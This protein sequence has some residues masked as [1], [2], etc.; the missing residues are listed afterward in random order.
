MNTKFKEKI[1][2]EQGYYILA[3]VSLAKA[4]HVL[5][6]GDVFAMLDNYGSIRR[7]GFEQEGIF[8]DG[9]RFVSKKIL[10][11]GTKYPLLLNAAANEEDEH[12]II[13]FTNP[14]FETENGS[15]IKRGTLHFLR[16]IFLC[17][18]S[19]YER[20]CI[21]NHGIENIGFSLNIEI[22]A[23]YEDIFE[24]R[25]IKREKRG[26]YNDP[27]ITDK[28]VIHSYTGL[29]NITRVT[30]FSFDQPATSIKANKV[31]F[32][33]QLE[34]NHTKEIYFTIS[35]RYEH[36]AVSLPAWSVAHNKIR[37]KC[38]DLKAGR[39]TIETSNN[40]FNHWITRSTSD[41]FML[42]TETNYGLYPYAGIP[43]FNTIF[44]R[45]GLITAME[46]LWIYPDISKGVLCYLA[47]HQ[48][49]KS[50]PLHEAEP[51][52]ILHEQRK[53]EMA[54]LGEVPFGQYYGSIDSTPL[55]LMLAG[56]YYQRTAD[57]EFITHLW[58]C[59]EAA[60]NWM[61]QYGDMDNDDFLE[62]HRK[63]RVGLVQQGWKDSDDSIFHKDGSL[64]QAPI[65]L[66]EVQGYAYQAKIQMAHL[67]RAL[68]KIEMADSLE[69]QAAKLKEQ[70]NRMFWLEDLGT[71]AL[72]LDGRKQP[73]AVQTSN[74]GHCLFSGIASESAA[75]KISRLLTD[76][77][78]F[79]GWG[80][81]TV[82]D[83]ELRYNPM[84][85]HNGSIWPHDNA[86]I[87][88]GMSR[89]GYKE[90]SIKILKSFFDASKFVDFRLPE[91][92][93]G[94]KRR[95]GEGPTLYPVACNPQAWASASVFMLLQACLGLEIDCKN[96]LIFFNNP[97]LPE[98]LHETKITDLRVGNSIIDIIL[99]CHYNDVGINITKKQGDIEVLIRK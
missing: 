43:W 33:L 62:Y 37:E 8:Y 80:I 21:T 99:H 97:I 56:M 91:L 60:L 90:E 10:K 26:A 82:A 58:P 30:K 29:D 41:L 84:S 98:S 3:D 28:D 69:S 15:L 46:T 39:C 87:A 74:P 88:T 5:K 34:P 85:Y 57:I 12:L 49:K 72:A 51:G 32:Q 94:F 54:N 36:T 22:E 20:I 38:T 61:K 96:N 19:C 48:A 53:S 23:D 40:Q 76:D 44:G 9:T 17:D 11:I 70:F 25:G 79:S 68:D 18:T 2:T 63:E 95:K 67:A 42:L 65:S 64:A 6:F 4:E 13:D 47:A 24:V 16:S 86:L 77:A 81:R 75:E 73:C 78:F 14:D 45:D 71:Y 27:I 31:I 1:K 50:D 92:F 35:C 89:Y 93:C 59:L 52:K 83:G 7:F 66:C 55:F